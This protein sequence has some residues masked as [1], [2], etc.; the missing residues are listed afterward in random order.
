[1]ST[2]KKIL[3]ANPVGVLLL[4]V[5]GSVIANRVHGMV[6]KAEAKAKAAVASATGK[7]AA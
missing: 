1:M 3:P 7:A 2:K 6:M 4:V 5:V